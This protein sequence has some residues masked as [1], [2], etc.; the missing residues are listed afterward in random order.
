MMFD[1]ISTSMP[2]LSAGKLRALG[3]TTLARS[4]LLPGVPTLDE[5][6]L[7]GFEDV[8]FNGILA[9]A[10]TPKAVQARLQEAIA[11]AWRDPALQKRFGD[12][13]IDLIASASPD[14]YAAYIKAEVARYAKLARDANIRAD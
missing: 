9:P 12:R 3:V 7:K 11:K 2:H 4:P 14:E 6:G 5:S 8:T 1:Q 13:G 10:G